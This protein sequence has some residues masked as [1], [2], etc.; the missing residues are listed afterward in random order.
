MR[1]WLGV[2]SRPR[3]LT[4]LPGKECQSRKVKCDIADGSNTCARCRRLGLKCVINKSL[5][6]LLDDENQCACPASP[7]SVPR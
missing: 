5:Q 1:A 6:T 7:I 3:L 4:R 2:P